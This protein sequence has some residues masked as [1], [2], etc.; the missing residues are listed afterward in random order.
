[1][2]YV[3]VGTCTTLTL[4]SIRNPCDC[5]PQRHYCKEK[6]SC[7]MIPFGP[8]VGN[9]ISL[10]SFP[11]V[12]STNPCHIMEH[13]VYIRNISLHSVWWP[14]NLMVFHTKLQKHT[15]AHRHA[16]TRQIGPSGSSG[17]VISSGQIVRHLLDSIIYIQDNKNS[18]QKK[19]RQLST[20]LNSLTTDRQP[21]LQLSILRNILRQFGTQT[22]SDFNVILWKRFQ[23]LELHCQSKVWT[24]LL[25]K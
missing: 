4:Q 13:L 23:S 8:Q 19:H 17:E 5:S 2:L 6:P 7:V 20:T 24:R 18:I 9:K 12:Q 11:Y 21:K 1:M 25:I 15:R 3:G 10:R 14:L 22:N 16:R